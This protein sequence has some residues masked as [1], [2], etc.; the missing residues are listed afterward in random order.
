MVSVMR[1]GGGE[2]SS[3]DKK[4]GSFDRVGQRR[5]KWWVNAAIASLLL[6]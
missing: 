1:S 3:V 4:E 2:G 6:Y 5:G